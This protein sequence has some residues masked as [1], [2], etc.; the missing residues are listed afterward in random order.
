M[1]ADAMS[2]GD[3]YV[4]WGFLDRAA[5]TRYV[6]GR[7]TPDGGYCFYRTPQ[8]SVEEPNALDTLAALE[9]LQLLGVDI[10]EPRQ[11][12]DWLRGLQGRN[13][14]YPTLTIGWA[15]LRALNRLAAQ[16]KYSPEHWLYS[17][18]ETLCDCDRPRDW[19]RAIT[20][21]VH[22]CEL[23]RLRRRVIRSAERDSIVALLDAARAADGGWASPG[24]DL[25]TTATGLRVAQLVNPHC[26]P[27]PPL[28]AFLGAC[29]DEQL[30]LRLA[31]DA[32]TTSVGA[33]WG[34][35]VLSHAAGWRLRYLG[36]VEKQLA[37]LQ[38][39]DGG[40]GARHRAV[41]GLQ[42]TWLGLQAASL[43]GRLRE[44]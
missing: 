21:A 16:P 7:R 44:E 33:L 15:A 18:F 32:A 13:G 37:M 22:L 29:E 10:P 39:P 28:A 35:L 2:A 41:S 6:M 17:R 26:R 38:R 1:S 23:L 24:S 4:W 25:E 31:P 3:P 42:S 14:A 8:W 27:D 12:A 30:G 34:G 19:R 11:T 9:S 20:D 43:L 40:L 36:A 5:I